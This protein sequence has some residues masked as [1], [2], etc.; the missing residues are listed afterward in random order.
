MKTPALLSTLNE[1]ALPKDLN[2]F[3]GTMQDEHCSDDGTM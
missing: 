3:T 1:D 2:D